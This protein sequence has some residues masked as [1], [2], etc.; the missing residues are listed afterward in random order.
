VTEKNAHARTGL[1][2]K[3][4]LI[5]ASS[6]VIFQALTEAKYLVQ[7][8]CDRASSDPRVGGELSAFWKAGKSGQ[9]GRAVFTRLVPDA[10]VELHWL[11]DAPL[12]SEHST[13]H[14]LSY[15]IQ[16]K[17]ESTE[18]V[19]RDVGYCPPDEETFTVLDEGWNSVLLELKDHCERKERSARRKAA[20]DYGELS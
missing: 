11:D 4:V 15:Q 16:S 20:G 17:R 10:L 7:W 6:P 1:I 9:T 19:M 13:K 2:E 8:F 5:Q 12:V 18:V 3:K 14:L